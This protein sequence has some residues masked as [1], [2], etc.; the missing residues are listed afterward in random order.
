[1]SILIRTKTGNHPITHAKAESL[2]QSG[3]IPPLAK[4]LSSDDGKTWLTYAELRAHLLDACV[5]KGDALDIDQDLDLSSQAKKLTNEKAEDSSGAIGS[6]GA[7]MVKCAA[8]GS[9]V[10]RR[11]K[12]CPKCGDPVIELLDDGSP[13]YQVSDRRK[14]IGCLIAIMIPVISLSGGDN[15]IIVRLLSPGNHN[16]SVLKA[17]ISGNGLFIG[18]K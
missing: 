1:M 16:D 17:S 14:R 18:V 11:A 4:V 12:N 3:K 2:A 7:L 6:D 8:C 9:P 15:L 13:R 10:S 5:S